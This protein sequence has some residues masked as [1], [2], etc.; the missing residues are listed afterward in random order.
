M[1]FS[2][3]SFLRTGSVGGL[4]L[5]L[6]ACTAAA[7]KITSDELPADLALPSATPEVARIVRLI[8]RVGYGTRPG[9]LAGA[10]ALGFEAYLEQQLQ[11]DQVADPSANMVV[12]HMDSYHMDIGPLLTTDWHDALHELQAA[13]A[14]RALYSHRGLYEA[15][16]EFWSDHFNIYGHKVDKL[17]FLKIVDDREVIRPHALGKFRDLLYASSHS[18][19]MLFY[20]DNVVNLKDQPNENYAREIMELHTLGVNGGYTQQDVRELARILTGW[21]IHD[22]GLNDGELFFN[23]DQHDTDQKILLGHVFPAGRG[24]EELRDA[25]E[26]LLAHPSTAQFIAHKLVRRF[27]ADDPPA[28]LVDQVAGVYKSTD[29]DIRSMLRTIFLSAHFEGAPPKLRRPYTFMIAAL[30][31]LNCDVA[32]RAYRPLFDRWLHDL[33]QPLFEWP[34][35]DGYPDMAKAWSASLLPRWNFALSLLTGEIEGVSVPFDRLLEAG[36]AAKVDDA[37]T[38]FSGLLFG[39]PLTDSERTG[40]S[41]YVGSGKLT[42]GET[43]LRLKEAVALMLASPAFQ[44]I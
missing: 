26:I 37:L 36:D 17:V 18:P 39:R 6:S 11:P 21:H 28:D 23:P 16:V 9:D 44:W 10:A 42:D 33:G 29:G 12:R 5:F 19:A 1:A 31:A 34:P 20:L 8:N 2:R 14:G 27:V 30:R 43:S 41:A 32:G 24:E 22:R 7:R 35:P 40:L 4:A 3:R 15:M 13:T 25:L 38:L